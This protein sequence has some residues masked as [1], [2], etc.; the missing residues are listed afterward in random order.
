[1]ENTDTIKDIV[2]EA[3]SS[4]AD[5]SGDAEKAATEAELDRQI[6]EVAKEVAKEEAKEEVTDKVDEAVSEAIAKVAGEEEVEASKD[7]SLET[8]INDYNA[9]ISKIGSLEEQL[10]KVK[11]E[12]DKLTADHKVA[13]AR[14]AQGFRDSQSIPVSSLKSSYEAT[15]EVINNTVNEILTKI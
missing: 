3:I 12:N 11:E 5:E 4:V 9:S 10:A 8:L 7:V 2:D 1:M 13:L 15:D 14:L 6:N